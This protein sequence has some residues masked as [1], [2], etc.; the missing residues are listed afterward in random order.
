MPAYHQRN[1][2]EYVLDHNIRDWCSMSPP[3]SP[4]TFTIPNPLPTLPS[5]YKIPCKRPHP[6]NSQMTILE[7]PCKKGCNILWLLH[8]LRN[9]LYK[10]LSWKT[11]L[12]TPKLFCRGIAP[13]ASW[14]DKIGQHRSNFIS[15]VLKKK[16]LQVTRL[17]ISNISYTS[18]KLT[19]GR[20]VLAISNDVKMHMLAFSI[21]RR[22]GASKRFSSVKLAQ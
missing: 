8:V 19:D 3:S 4:K 14:T 2:K 20:I 10:F 12:P 22:H 17:Y 11:L 5:D 7:P 21:K 1:D 13:G 9:K 16:T 15:T 6:S 18:K